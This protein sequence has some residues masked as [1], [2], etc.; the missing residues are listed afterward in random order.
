MITLKDKD[1]WDNKIVVY[2]YGKYE[3]IRHDHDDDQEL[4]AE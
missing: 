3:K 4:A 2:I 1:L